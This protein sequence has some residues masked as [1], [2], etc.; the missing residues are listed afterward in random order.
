MYHSK[1]PKEVQDVIAEKFNDPES[2]LKIVV[3]SSLFSMGKTYQIMF[4]YN[5]AFKNDSSSLFA[6]GNLHIYRLFLCKQLLY[7]L[8]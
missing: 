1:V 6:V 3:C 8:A 5:I 7:F 4:K 2:K